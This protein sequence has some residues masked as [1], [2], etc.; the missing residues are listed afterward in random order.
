MLLSRFRNAL[1]QEFLAAIPSIPPIFLIQR[2]TVFLADSPEFVLVRQVAMVFALTGNVTAKVIQLGLADGE[3]AVAVLPGEVGILR[4]FGF[5][6]FRGVLLELLDEFAHGDCSRECAGNVYMVVGAANGMG[7]AIQ[8]F[9]IS[10][11]VGREFGF[12]RC[13]DPPLALFGA[14]D[15]MQQDV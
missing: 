15:D 8:S 13:V 3:G 2:H 4:A 6:P 5:E 14:K 12:Y 1:P 10:G 9:A 7:W 11:E